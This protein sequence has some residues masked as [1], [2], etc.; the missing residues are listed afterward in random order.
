[1]PKIKRILD[2][3]DD[4][5]GFMVADSDLPV[6]GA[7]KIIAPTNEFLKNIKKGDFDFVLIKQDTHFSGEYPINPESKIFPNIHCEYGTKAWKLAIKAELIKD[8]PV[9]YMAKDRFDMWSNDEARDDISFKNSE[10]EA[11]YDNLFNIGSD[12]LC[13]KIGIDRDEFLKNI[14]ADTEVVIIGV[15]SDYCVHDAMLGYLKKG[16]KLTI[17]TD[18]VRGIGTPVS[19]RALSGD[20]IDVVKLPCFKK[21]LDSGKI[22][23]QLSKDIF[24]KPSLSPKS[25]KSK[26]R[27]K[28]P[29]F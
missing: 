16:A 1:M 12:P 5:I 7:D 24:K 28:K 22:S 26:K 21:Y 14:G 25:T 27:V 11:A 9:Y 10:E 23:L 3:V 2:I 29:K 18:L 15:A 8:T 20:I 6:S 4:Q 13:R 19:G 17:L